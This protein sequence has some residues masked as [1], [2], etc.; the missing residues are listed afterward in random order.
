MAKKGNRIALQSAP[1]NVIGESAVEAC[2]RLARRHDFER[3]LATLFA[4]RRRR[5]ALWILLAFNA[6]IA[7]TRQ[8]VSEAALGQIRLQWW[9]EAVDTAVADGPVRQHEVAAPLAAAL[10][11]GALEPALLHRLIDG[12]A[13]D[14]DDAPMADEAALLDYAAQTGGALA[15]AMALAAGGG[16]ADPE[17]RRAARESARAL[18]TGWA[19]AGI[20][21][22]A[23]FH[24]G[25]G[26]Q[27]LPQS[28]LAAG[29]AGP[30]DLAER[31]A[32]AGVRAAA[33]AV[34][35]M[36]R[37]R[38]AAA[39]RTGGPADRLLVLKPVA[40][41]WLDRLERAGFD[42]FGVPD[43]LAPAHTPALMLAAR[44]FGRGL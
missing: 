17:T 28:A 23:S 2:R 22:A 37:D 44:W 18:G 15:E 19:L 12:R 6:E 16:P 41:A 33:E 5:P 1:E 43:R 9:R 35:A 24:A 10:R 20:L 25:G 8:I 21:R 27:L 36:A 3:Y 4:P 31:R 11:A 42:P 29:G 30:R 7:R 14:L 13:R 34:A 39:G 32:T 38:L 26:R 40:L